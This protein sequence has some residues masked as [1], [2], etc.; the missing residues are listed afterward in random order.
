MGEAEV[1]R[2][3]VYRSN[4]REGVYLYTTS[5]EDFAALPSALVQLMGTPRL[6]ME[7]ELYPG[8][9]LA[10]AAAEAV[11]DALA[12]DGFYLQMPPSEADTYGT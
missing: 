6:V 4:R 8:R 12:R 10:R 2:C 5:P 9:R 3:W 11:M 7:L 1:V